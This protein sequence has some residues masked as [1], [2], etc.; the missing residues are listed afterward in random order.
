[1]YLKTTTETQLHLQNALLCK[2]SKE[3]EIRQVTNENLFFFY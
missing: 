2:D 1:M 3:F